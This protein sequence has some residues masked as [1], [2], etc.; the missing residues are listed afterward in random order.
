MPNVATLQLTP[1]YHFALR[2]N[3][4]DLKNRFGDVEAELS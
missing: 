4:M 3:A 2:I 1:D